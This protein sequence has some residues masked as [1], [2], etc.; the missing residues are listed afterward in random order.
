MLHVIL[1]TCTR[2]GVSLD[3]TSSLTRICGP[4]RK[5]M[6]FKCLHS[7]VAS[8]NVAVSISNNFTIN[9][10]VLDDHSP[11]EDVQAMQQILKKANF[12]YVL[13]PLKCTGSN[14]TA[15]TQFEYGLDLGSQDDYL[16][17][18]ED[19]YLH[20]PEA[21]S[22]MLKATQFFSQRSIKPVA[23]YPFD[24]PH[25]YREISKEDRACR[26]H[27]A[28]G[29]YWRTTW[30]T[31]NT[32]MLPWHIVRDYWTLFNLLATQY[33]VLDESDTINNLW[34]NDVD[35][36]GIVTLY[37]P[38]PSLAVHLTYEDVLPVASHKFV[39]QNL[40]NSL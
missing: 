40:W 35:S 12:D 17:F 16:Y 7:L 22:E 27:F 32:V 37:S 26:I 5:E 1:R 29:R 6:V 19:D 31:A 18:V 4:N 20:W 9:L 11:E 15:L 28:N 10:H 21:I 2:T 38:I 30:A 36:K 8:I 23:I 24:C 34:S 3:S 13:L 25:R 14:E 33:P 39:W